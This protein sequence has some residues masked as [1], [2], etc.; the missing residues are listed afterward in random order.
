M[1]TAI[2]IARKF[3]KVL[4]YPIGFV[5]ALVA[6]LIALLPCTFIFTVAAL[7]GRKPTVN[8]NH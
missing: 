4:T 5:L 8:N 2:R 6:W 1:I 7:Q 3:W